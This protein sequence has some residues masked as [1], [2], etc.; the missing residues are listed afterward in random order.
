MTEG[1]IG[2]SAN[3]GGLCLAGRR[4][5]VAFHKVLY[6]PKILHKGMARKSVMAHVKQGIAKR[7][8]GG[9][10]SQKRK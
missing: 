2:L 8:I 1:R 3:A 9:E 5:L 6:A 7:L 10:R 4:E